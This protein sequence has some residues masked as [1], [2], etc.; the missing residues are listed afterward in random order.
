MSNVDWAPEARVTLVGPAM[1]SETEWEA[2]EERVMP[3]RQCR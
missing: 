1:R 2:S 3:R